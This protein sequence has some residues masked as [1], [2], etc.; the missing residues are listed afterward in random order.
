MHYLG[1]PDLLD[2]HGGTD[3]VQVPPNMIAYDRGLEQIVGMRLSKKGMYRWYASCCKTPLGNTIVPAVPFI[4]LPLEIFRS[5]SDAQRIEDVFGKPRSRVMGKFAVGGA[6]EG[7]T[8]FPL[9]A[10]AQA[11]TKVLGW[12]LTGKT[13]PHPYFDEVTRAPKYPVTVLQPQDREALRAKC[14]PNPMSH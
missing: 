8:G 2:E 3:V 12:K 13:W 7:S 14:G 4:G 5:A 10:L 1:R 9:R 11:L 6:P